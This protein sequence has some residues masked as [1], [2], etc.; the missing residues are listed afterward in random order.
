MADADKNAA[1]DVPRAIT[2]A[3]LTAVIVET[4]VFVIPSQCVSLSAEYLPLLFRNEFEY[5]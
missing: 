5:A 4:T 3:V 2:A 1:V